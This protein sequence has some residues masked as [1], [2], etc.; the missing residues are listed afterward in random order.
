MKHFDITQWS[1]FIRGVGQESAA[2]QEHLAPGC[3]ECQRLVDTLARVSEVLSRDST[4]EPPAHVIRAVKALFALQ[5]PQRSRVLERLPVLV[6]H[7]SAQVPAVVAGTRT[8]EQSTRQLLYEAELFAVDLRMDYETGS[9]DLVLVGQVVRKGDTPGPVAEVPAFLLSQEEVV[10]GAITG[11]L[12]EFHI[13][14]K[15]DPSLKL[16][17]LVGETSCVEL[18]LD[19]PT[20]A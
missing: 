14:A 5:K 4:Q 19:P 10:A 6:R 12:G 20:T 1:D 8:L 16:C 18:S 9:R 7:D 15:S 13:N 3:E 11:R 2:M 17:L